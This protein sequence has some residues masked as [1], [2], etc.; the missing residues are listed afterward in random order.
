M[1]RRQ[2]EIDLLNVPTAKEHGCLHSH[3]LAIDLPP[4]ASARRDGNANASL[5][6]NEGLV[7]STSQPT[8]IRNDFKNVTGQAHHDARHPKARK[9]EQV[10]RQVHVPVPNGAID[11]SCGP[12]LTEYDLRLLD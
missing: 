1:L 9:Q 2:R 12:F 10:D 3:A 5:V 11:M 4:V 6:A 8:E 7:E